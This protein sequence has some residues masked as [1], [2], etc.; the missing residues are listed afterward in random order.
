MDFEKMKAT[1]LL[2]SVVN[3]GVP[4]IHVEKNQKGNEIYKVRCDSFSKI[5]GKNSSFGN[6][7]TKVRRVLVK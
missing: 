6:K 4:R 7:G 3:G 5:R 2:H 1:A